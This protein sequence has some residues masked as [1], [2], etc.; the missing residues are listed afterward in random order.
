MSFIWVLLL[1]G[2][3]MYRNF[4]FT[5]IYKIDKHYVLPSNDDDSEDVD[6]L[7]NCVKL[8]N[9]AQVSDTQYKQ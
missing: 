9:L 2:I 5:C 7:H 4:L 3:E 6:I 8:N 1:Y